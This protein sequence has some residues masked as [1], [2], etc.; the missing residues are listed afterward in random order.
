MRDRIVGLVCGVV[1]SAVIGV[2]AF[3]MSIP[4]LILAAVLTVLPIALFVRGNE[5]AGRSRPWQRRFVAGLMF[6]AAAAAFA[7]SFGIVQLWSAVFVLLGA[8]F[9]GLS[10]LLLTS[11]QQTETRPAS[12]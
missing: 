2:G 10:I 11:R 6:S 9:Y 4:A 1:G 3:W 7:S 5:G 8:S 12:A